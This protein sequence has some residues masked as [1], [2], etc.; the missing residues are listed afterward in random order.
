MVSMARIQ[1]NLLSI[2][3]NS[4]TGKALS[5]RLSCLNGKDLWAAVTPFRAV[6]PA[7]QR[8][9]RSVLDIDFIRGG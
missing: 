5:K 4:T 2:Q 6:G 1:S 9:T 7:K 8:K 3:S